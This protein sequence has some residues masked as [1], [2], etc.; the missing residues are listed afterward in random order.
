MNKR[1]SIEDLRL[2]KKR[3]KEIKKGMKTER[4]PS[5]PSKAPALTSIARKAKKQAKKSKRTAT[6]EGITNSVPANVHVEGKRWIATTRKQI[7]EQSLLARKTSCKNKK[8]A[9]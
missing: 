6:H 3:T 7:K 1:H 9:A 8:R 4:L 5:L 2:N